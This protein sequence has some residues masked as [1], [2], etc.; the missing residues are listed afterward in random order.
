[1][2]FCSFRCVEAETLPALGFCVDVFWGQ[3]LAHPGLSFE[4]PGWYV[5][6]KLQKP[7][8]CALQCLDY[9]IFMG[10][11]ARAMHVSP[12]AMPIR[13]IFRQL[14]RRFSTKICES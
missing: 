7:A 3:G 12:K 6:V 14:G 13:V 10:E 5:S 4:P 9:C 2:R 8:G 1:M 11:W